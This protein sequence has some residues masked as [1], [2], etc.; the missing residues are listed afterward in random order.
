MWDGSSWGPLGAG[1]TGTVS[2][3]T[4]TPA[5]T[6]LA[7]GSGPAAELD[8]AVWRPLGT[9]NSVTNVNAIVASS[10]GEIAVGGGFT[11][12]GERA[13]A[14]FARFAVPDDCCSADFD[15]NGAAEVPDIF[16]FLS[17]WFAGSGSTDYDGNGQ[18]EV[19]DI[20]AFLCA[21]FAGC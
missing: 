9:P 2:S 13:S 4:L 12:V 1:L 3:L 14:H 18:R 21:W 5:G 16:A 6:M 7:A 11:R 19:P 10:D 17:A 20:F 15:G 8:G